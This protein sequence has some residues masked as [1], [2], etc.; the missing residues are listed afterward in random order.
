MNNGMK[1]NK[2]KCWIFCLGQSNDGHR[3]KLVEEWL[4]GSGGAG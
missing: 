1:L 2:A 3:Y 4:G